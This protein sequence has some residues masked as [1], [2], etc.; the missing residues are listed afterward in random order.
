MIRR[1][2]VCILFLAFGLWTE[3]AGAEEVRIAVAANFAPAIKAIQADFERRFGTRLR[4]STGSTGQLYAQILQGADYQVYL[5]ADA[6]FPARAVEEGLGVKGTR[7]PYALGRLVLYSARE[8]ALI[9]GAA[10]LRQP[11]WNKLAMADPTVAPYGKAAVQV[12]K[13]MEVWSQV[14][15][16]IVR[17]RSVTQ[18]MKF[19]VTGNAELGFVSLSQVIHGVRGK[20]WLVPE[21]WHQPIRQEAVLLQPGN[22][23]AAAE[24]FL[25]YLKSEPAAAIL[26]RFGYEV[27]WK[28]SN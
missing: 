12:M 18:A 13:K 10:T 1:R 28:H 27:P 6:D 11:G 2:W 21:H 3:P 15:R 14:K 7:F 22:G 9:Q 16:K 26:T 5:A 20:Y 8:P 23:N 17:G 19:V 24:D 25:T 4:I